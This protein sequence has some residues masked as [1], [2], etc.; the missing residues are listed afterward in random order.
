MKKEIKT[1]KSL[2]KL[3]INF[4]PYIF[5]FNYAKEETIW[6]KDIVDLILKNIES[7]TCYDFFFT[8]LIN[9][10]SDIRSYFTEE[11]I[12]MGIDREYFIA[13]T[14]TI[15]PRLWYD[16][17]AYGLFKYGNIHL[18]I[19]CIKEGDKRFSSYSIRTNFSIKNVYE[20]HGK[21]GLSLIKENLQY[22][23]N[24]DMKLLEDYYNRDN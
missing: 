22:F 24:L 10:H 8:I 21:E 4:N 2:E 13:H 19:K 1:I 23:P 7:Y 6:T 20:Y 16:D 15:S 9:I 18:I 11:E 12:K 3:S 14:T 5:N 17:I